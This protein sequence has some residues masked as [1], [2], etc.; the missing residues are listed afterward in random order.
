MAQRNDEFRRTP[1]GFA[2]REMVMIAVARAASSARTARVPLGQVVITSGIDSLI[3]EGSLELHDLLVVLERHGSCD[4]GELGEEDVEAN[5]SAVRDDA[6]PDVLSVYTV[7]GVRLWVKT[8]AGQV[9]TV[10]LPEEY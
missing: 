5:N 10:L 9:M 8:D 7:N 2:L 6:C 4:W 1:D 3:R